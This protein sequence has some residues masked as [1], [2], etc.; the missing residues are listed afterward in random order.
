[1]WLKIIQ[2]NTQVT[3]RL[4]R[5]CLVSFKRKMAC[6]DQNVLLLMDQSAFHSDKVTLRCVHLCLQPDTTSCMQPLDQ[7]IICGVKWVCSTSF[8]AR[9]GQECSHRR[10]EK[11]EYL[12]CHVR[13]F[14]GMEIH[15]ACSNSCPFCKMWHLP[16]RFSKH[17]QYWKMWMGGPAKPHWL[18]QYF[19]QVS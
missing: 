17:Q 19:Q 5:K 16:W 4:F 15:H 10:H 13:Y 18:P 9:R 2:K 3:G 8:F 11:L 7:V 1:M 14:L 6:Q 12:W